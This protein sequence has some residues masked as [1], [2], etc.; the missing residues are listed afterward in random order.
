MTKVVVTGGSGILGRAVVKHLVQAGY[1]V[2]SLDRVEFPTDDERQSLQ[3]QVESQV[4]DLTNAEAVQSALAGCE[5]VVHLAAIPNP[6]HDPWPLVYANNTVSSY[7]VLHA[8]VTLGIRRICMASS[9]NALGAAYSRAPHFDYFP[10]DERHPTYNEDA[11]S[12][13]KWVME[14]QGDSFARRW[15][16]T[17][18]ATLRLHGIVENA[19]Q[20]RERVEH[21][22]S[23]RAARGLWGYVNIEACAR[24][25]QLSIEAGYHGHE[26]FFIV[27][28]NT[29]SQTPSLELAQKFYPGTPVTG[30][31]RDQ[32][33]FFDTSKATRLLQ[34]KHET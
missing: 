6:V 4:V 16:G 23:D 30:D 26:V 5:A 28:T 20:F 7:N 3:D 25:C 34:W 2:R 21:F 8:A 10:V 24:A 12:L 31:L 33:A 13:S 15:E 17:T 11:Y 32:K 22:A 27:A 9:I 1:A 18:I 14:Q 29:Y 19:E